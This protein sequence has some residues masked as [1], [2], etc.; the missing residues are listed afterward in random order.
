M[1]F[2]ELKHSTPDGMISAALNAPALEMAKLHMQGQI[3]KK[4]QDAGDQ[5]LFWEF[6]TNMLPTRFESFSKI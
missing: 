6:L 1:G 5:I 3:C 4:V 2:S